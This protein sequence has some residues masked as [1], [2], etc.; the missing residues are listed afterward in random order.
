[1]VRPSGKPTPGPP[2]P[3]RQAWSS[4][5]RPSSPASAHG[6][7]GGPCPPWRPA[8][9]VGALIRL[10]ATRLQ[11]QP[12]ERRLAERRLDPL[13]EI[14]GN[15]ERRRLERACECALQ[16]ALG[17]WPRRARPPDTDPGAATRR[18]RAD[19][20]R[21]LAARPEREPDQLIPGSC[22]P[23]EDAAALRDMPARLGS[24]WGFPQP[25]PPRLR[26]R[27]RTNARGRP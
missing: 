6:S 23:R 14:G 3:T 17:D 10:P 9:S 4:R 18:P 20:R 13:A 12:V 25:R 8:R 26:A 21:D 27:P 1:M 19:I 24:H 15:L 7:A 16:L 11:S 22:P 5:L 2:P